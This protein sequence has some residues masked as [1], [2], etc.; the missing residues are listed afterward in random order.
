MKRFDV[1]P[2]ALPNGPAGEVRFEEARDVEAVE[3]VFQG[4]APR[5]ARLQYMRKTWPNDRF[6]RAPDLDQTRPSTFGWIRMDDLFTPEWVDA[7]ADVSP[8][9]P[10][11]LCCAAA[12]RTRGG[13]WTPTPASS[14]RWQRNS[15][16]D[17]LCARAEG[18]HRVLRPTAVARPRRSDEPMGAQ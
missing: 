9:R 14:W 11:A 7:A 18:S 12:S 4:A 5:N 15:L 13:R 6:E 10:R 17:A 3:F 8:A 1:A 16:P 2:F